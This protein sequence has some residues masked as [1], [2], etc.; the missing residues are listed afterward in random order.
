VS[1][2]HM[3]DAAYAAAIPPGFQVAA[4]YYGGPNAYHVWP[5][6]DWAR[7]PGMR[8]PIWVGGRAGRSEG[9][10]AV[11]ALRQLRVPEGSITVVDMETRIDETYL[12]EFA[13]EVGPFYRIWPYGSAS[14]IF[15]NPELNGY[16][17]ADYT[18]QPFM[19]P[20]VGVRATQ[21]AAGLPGA[22]GGQYDASLVKPWVVPFLWTGGG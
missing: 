13:V 11:A 19:H 6:A 15:S 21:Y 9:A 2:L 16:W 20:A 14:T 10:A 3:A 8:L 22:G 12:L 7:F 17:V 4:G 5:D 1:Y 18:G